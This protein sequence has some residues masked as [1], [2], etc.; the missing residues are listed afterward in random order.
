MKTTIKFSFLIGMLMSTLF[1]QAQKMKTDTLTVYGNCGMCKERIENALDVKGIASAEWNIKTKILT[2]TYKQ[3][4]IDLNQISQM[5]NKVGHDTRISAASDE[6][7]NKLH[8]CCNYRHN[9][10]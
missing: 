4:K 6:D 5:V 3:D 1:V 10:E 2:V 8:G 9:K 7:Y